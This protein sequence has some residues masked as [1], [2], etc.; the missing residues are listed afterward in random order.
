MDV[1]KFEIGRSSYGNS[2]L[3]LMQRA[4]L[5]VTFVALSR[6][7]NSSFVCITIIMI[8]IINPTGVRR[9]VAFPLNCF[10]ISSKAALRFALAAIRLKTTPSPYELEVPITSFLWQQLIISRT[11]QAFTYSADSE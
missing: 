4:E 8:I 6:F 11:L 7:K 10:L 5:Q 9:H 2:T 1:L 3:V